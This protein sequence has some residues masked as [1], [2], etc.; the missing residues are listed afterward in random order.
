MDIDREVELLC[1]EIKRLGTTNADGK[2]C[3]KFK[4]LMDDDKCSNICASPL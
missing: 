2:I 3:V 4:T 1:E